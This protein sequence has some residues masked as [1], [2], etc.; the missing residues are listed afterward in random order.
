MLAELHPVTPA[1]LSELRRLELTGAT[2]TAGR[3][4]GAVPSPEE[5]AA[6]LWAGV[7]AQRVVVVDGRAVGL[8]GA[9]D[10]DPRSGTAWLCAWGAHEHVGTGV[11]AGGVARFVEWLFR[12]WPMRVLYAATTEDALASFRAVTGDLATEVARY[13]DRHRRGGRFV[14]RVVL[15]CDRA[16]VEVSIRPR[17]DA[18]MRARPLDAPPTLDGMVLA[19]ADELGRPA[20]ALGPDRRVVAD[21]GLD[22][23]ELFLVALWIEEHGGE[24]PDPALWQTA[25]IAELHRLAWSTAHAQRARCLT[26]VHV[27]GSGPHP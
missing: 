1:N 3:F 27:G 12:A 17:L 8:V 18:A 22:S 25:T 13:P 7:L 21:L 20:S 14:D 4:A 24:L 11:V 19:L 23:L 6:A 9:H 10:P 26:D 5:Y 2:A 15:A 16:A